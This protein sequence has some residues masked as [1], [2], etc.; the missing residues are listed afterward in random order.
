MRFSCPTVVPPSVD[1]RMAPERELRAASART[2]SHV[3]SHAMCARWVRARRA[4]ARASDGEIGR[5]GNLWTAPCDERAVRIRPRGS[6]PCATML[7]V[8]FTAPCSVKSSSAAAAVSVFTTAMRKELPLGSESVVFICAESVNTLDCPTES[9]KPGGGVL[10]VHVTGIFTVT[11]PDAVSPEYGFGAGAVQVLPTF[12][13]L[14]LPEP[15]G[16]L[17]M[18]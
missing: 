11:W 16:T 14:M 15:V 1:F 7:A 8:G 4:S 17:V 6:G 9:D 3:L 12:D 13:T 18:A 10:G 2:A 5:M